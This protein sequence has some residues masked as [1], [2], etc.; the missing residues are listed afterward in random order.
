M[1]SHCSARRFS[2]PGCLA[3]GEV[4]RGLG[5]NSFILPRA[6]NPRTRLNGRKEG[7]AGQRLLDSRWIATGVRNAVGGAH[8]VGG[9]F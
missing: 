5:L 6:P 9:A 3:F 2:A 8:L 7:A 1:S 4:V